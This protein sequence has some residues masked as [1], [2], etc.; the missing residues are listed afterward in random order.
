[1]KCGF[2]QHGVVD[3]TPFLE[4][5][6]SNPEGKNLVRQ[7]LVGSFSGALSFRMQIIHYLFPESV[8]PHREFTL[9]QTKKEDRVE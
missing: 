6:Y 4:V 1:L 8:A 7:Y 9:K 2:G 3:E 5:V